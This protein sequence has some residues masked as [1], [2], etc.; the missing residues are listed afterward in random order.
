LFAQG[1]VAKSIRNRILGLVYPV[2]D[3]NFKVAQVVDGSFLKISGF[4]LDIRGEG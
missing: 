1:G 2:I 4:V 3:G